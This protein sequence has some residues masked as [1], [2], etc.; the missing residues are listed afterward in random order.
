MIA[1]RKEKEMLEMTMR[2][3]LHRVPKRMRNDAVVQERI[4]LYTKLGKERLARAYIKSLTL[5][6]PETT[7]LVTNPIDP[8][9]GEQDE[10]TQ[11]AAP[12]TDDQTDYEAVQNGTEQK[13]ETKDEDQDNADASPLDP[14]DDDDDDDT[15]L[16]SDGNDED[17][18]MDSDGDDDD[19]APAPGASSA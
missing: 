3:L 14:D 11:A 19:P 12:Q 18:P 10:V 2:R 17:T 6:F 1:K 7:T 5:K 16:D 4:K 13:A 8:P 15:P 9:L